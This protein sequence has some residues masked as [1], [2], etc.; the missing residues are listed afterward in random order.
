VESVCIEVIDT[1]KDNGNSA[2]AAAAIF[3]RCAFLFRSFAKVCFSY[4][5]Y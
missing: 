2:G 5:S 4:C 1:M 3:L